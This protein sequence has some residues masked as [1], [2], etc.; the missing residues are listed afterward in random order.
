MS[1]KATK[2]EP[3]TEAAE[4]QPYFVPEQSKT[5][6]AESPEKAVEIAKKGAK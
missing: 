3:K 5:V 2:S 4:K 6:V 1:E